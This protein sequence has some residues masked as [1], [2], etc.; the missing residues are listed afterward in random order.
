VGKRG[1]GEGSIYRRKDGRWVGQYTAQTATGQKRRYVYG[2]TRAEAAAKLAKS[3]ANR[4]VGLTFDAGNL[5]VSEYLTAWLN[6]SVR[7]RY[8][9]ALIGATSNCVGA[10][11]YRHSET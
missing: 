9:L 8:G 11:S 6:D 2:K 3:I 1:N 7:G 5:T 10:T 4:D